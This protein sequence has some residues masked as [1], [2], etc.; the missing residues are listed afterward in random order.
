MRFYHFSI[1]SFIGFYVHYLSDSKRVINPGGGEQSHWKGVWG[2][3]AVM[4]PFFRPVTAPYPTNLLSMRRSCALCFQFLEN[5]CIFS[6]VLAKNSSSLDR[7]WSKFSFL[8]PLF[9]KENL[10]PRPYILKPAWHTSTK[11]KLSAPPG[12]KIYFFPFK[13]L[14]SMPQCSIYLKNGEV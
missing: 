11:K 4:T 12:D 6:L 3:A 2:C 14:C 1:T 9:L 10:L 8:R 13:Y 5:F 7:N